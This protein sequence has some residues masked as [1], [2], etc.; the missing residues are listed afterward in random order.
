FN[1]ATTA[2]RV[3][4]GQ[5]DL[6]KAA[7]IQISDVGPGDRVL[8]TLDPA[9]ANSARRII[10]IT[11]GDIAKRNADDRQD[12][13]KRGVAGL[14][15]AVKGNEISL[16]QK[17]LGPAAKFTVKAGDMT[18]FKRYAPDSVKFADAQTS[19]LSEVS[20]G[21]QLRARGEKSADG[22]TVD[23]SE[24]IFGTFLSKA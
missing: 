7:T 3:A 17:T 8:V 11:S 15:T 5:T 9:A 12:W 13:T 20:V 16:E 23:A 10:V 4:P 22:L 1:S 21:D 19:K 6:S 24:V 2:Q 18:V 14:V